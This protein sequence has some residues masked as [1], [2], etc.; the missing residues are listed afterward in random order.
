MR[1]KQPT[2]A[3]QPL[4]LPAFALF[5]LITVLAFQIRL[6]L[7]A[8]AWIDRITIS[9]AVGIT[10]CAAGG[11][12][13][14]NRTLRDSSETE[15]RYRN[16]VDSID[17]GFCIIE[18]I[19]DS[20]GRPV[21][22]RFLEVNPAFERQTGIEN[23]RGRTMRE[24]TPLHEQHWF[25]TY[26]RV[27]LTGEPTRFQNHA[28]QLGRWFDVHA[29]P[30]DA[31]CL[32]RVA[33]LFHDLTER[34]RIEQEIRESTAQFRAI[35]ERAPVGIEQV[36]LDGRLLMVNSTQCGILGYTEAEML[37]L[38]FEDITHPADRPREAALLELLFSG[39]QES[40]NM[41]KRYVHKNGTPVW[42][43]IT[44]TMVR[45]RDGA[46]EYRITVVE[47]ITTRKHA[48]QAIINTEKLAVA[49]RMAA[50]M[51]HEINNPLGAA[52]NSLY[53]IS[54]DQS[55]SE[56][57]CQ[58]L[59]FA[60]RELERVAHITKQT[61]GF[62][63]E[64]GSPTKVDLREVADDVIN[65]YRPKLNNKDV[66]V[67]L[68]FQIGVPIYGIEGELR[69][70]LSN[71]FSNSIDAV[72]TQ[73]CIRLRIAGP[74]TLDGK[75]PVAR[76]T[77]SDDGVGIPRQHIEKI[78]E[79]FFSTKENT[80]TGLGLWVTQQLVRKHGGKIRVRS[81]PGVGS[82]FQVYLPMERRTLERITQGHGNRDLRATA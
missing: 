7:L 57:N 41:E 1:W 46:P 23:A 37:S 27:A 16:L 30:I 59:D 14:C 8:S 15:V 2:R 36:A 73:G 39:Q 17:E 54:L 18:M 11:G 82:V 24:I 50:A 6:L 72:D 47:D 35:Y 67:D 79:P 10:L 26:G 68:R 31:P 20:E 49:G 60:Q 45:S 38:T 3:A 19:Y 55:L 29:F 62:Y 40:Y 80:G 25:D 33:V 51:A 81:K 12:V 34:L 13:Y 56:A 76:L 65:L 43:N 71:L 52:L 48:E 75:R 5:A 77:V 44:S 61:L 22:Y 78:F 74:L 9:L 4:L 70:V 64:T 28:T 63:R 32:H 42:V 21:D 53:L 58:Y 66:Q 69:Q